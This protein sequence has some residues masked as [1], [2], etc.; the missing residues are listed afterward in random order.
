MRIHLRTITD[1]QG[2]AIEYA[3][4][5]SRS[6]Y[7][8]SLE[9]EPVSETFEEGGAYPCGS[10][11]DYPD[12]CATC[13]DPIGNPLTAEGEAYVRE[14]VSG[15]LEPLREAWQALRIDGSTRLTFPA[16]VDCTL[17]PETLNRV[18]ALEAEYSYLWRDEA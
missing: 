9:R 4:Y 10:E 18:R 11:H 7:L 12:Y 1:N 13:G 14:Y 2:D 6:C 5:C 8:T 16:Y 17:A 3:W 15:V